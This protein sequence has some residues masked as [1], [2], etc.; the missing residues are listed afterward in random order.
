MPHRRLLLALWIAGCALVAIQTPCAGQLSARGEQFAAKSASAAWNEAS[1]QSVHAAVRDVALCSAGMTNAVR[2]A[3]LLDDNGKQALRKLM[4]LRFDTPGWFQS[5]LVAAGTYY[6]GFE[7][8]ER[9]FWTVLWGPDGKRLSQR[10]FYLLDTTSLHPEIWCYAAEEGAVR[11][12]MGMGQILFQWRFVPQA[13]HDAITDGLREYRSGAVR[14]HSDLPWSD[15]LQQLARKTQH[16]LKAHERILHGKTPERSRFDIFLF[17]DVEDYKRMDRLVTGGEFQDRGGVTSH[18]TLRSYIGYVG[19]KSLPPGD[20]PQ[21]PQA[22]KFLAFHEVHHLLAQRLY[23]R[24]ASNWPTWLSEGLAEYGTALASR[25]SKNP[26]RYSDLLRGHRLYGKASRTTPSYRELLRGGSRGRRLA[27]Y[28]AAY[29]LIEELHKKP[30][31][32]EA[33]LQTY[34]SASL[35]TWRRRTYKLLAEELPELE[36]TYR[37]FDEEHNP[38]PADLAL[39][40]GY[41]DRRGNDYYVTAPSGEQGVVL[42]LEPQTSPVISF[43]SKFALIGD[44]QAD[45]YL[46]YRR[47]ERQLEF[48]KVAILPSRV[49]LFHCRNN[50]WAALG[51]KEYSQPLLISGRSKPRWYGLQIDLNPAEKQV[52]VSL[53]AREPLTLTYG[54]DFDAAGSRVGFGSFDSVVGFQLQ[55]PTPFTRSAENPTAPPSDRDGTPKTPGESPTEEL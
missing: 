29:R 15:L 26:V 41:L 38:G 19:R 54:I 28:A 48:L 53:Q 46:G 49:V 40:S 20:P 27:F 52:R 6:I 1:E 3:E 18:L 23:P 22:V 25:D 21:L 37:A 45:I 12:D 34:E 16:S 14:L 35:R 36:A 42:L 55:K 8:D 44:G 31:V 39:L 33:L 32:L 11:I 47:R 30:S 43:A 7:E 13:R 4:R 17:S 50:Q 10:W 51:S 2:N 5:T 24:S 9:G